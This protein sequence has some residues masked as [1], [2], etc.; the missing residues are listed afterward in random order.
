MNNVFGGYIDTLID[1]K[2]LVED[3]K[4]FVFSLKSNGRL[5]EL[6]KFAIK[7]DCK[8]DAFRLGNDEWDWLFWM[9]FRDIF[10]WKK[11]VDFDNFCEQHAF[12]Y[13]GVNNALCG[14][15]HFILSRFVVIQMI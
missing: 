4:A 2:C 11:G 15:T 7:S 10:I 14:N 6:E 8:R 13:H 12:D 9:G 5:Q 1:K 3:P